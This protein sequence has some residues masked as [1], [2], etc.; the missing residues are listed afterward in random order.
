MLR[1]FLWG[2]LWH[3]GRLKAGIWMPDFV[4]QCH[5]LFYRLRGRFLIVGHIGRIWDCLGENRSTIEM[6]VVFN[7][8]QLFSRAWP[9]CAVALGGNKTNPSS[10]EW[11]M[12]SQGIYSA[13]KARNE[14]PFLLLTSVAFC[15]CFQLAWEILLL[16]TKSGQKQRCYFLM[17]KSFIFIL[18]LCLLVRYICNC[19]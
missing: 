6:L 3:R 12:E 14:F 10:E 11:E 1:E 16:Q 7:I 17:S 18:V 8:W 13:V 19:F 5:L 4:L 9:S 2:I 15:R